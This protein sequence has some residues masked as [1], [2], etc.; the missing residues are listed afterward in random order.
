MHLKRLTGEL[1]WVVDTGPLDRGPDIAPFVGIRHDA[2]EALTAELLGVPLDRT[3][4]SVGDNVG[5]FMQ[6]EYRKWAG[7]QSVDDVLSAIDSA[8][9]RLL[10][11]LSL[12]NLLGVWNITSRTADPGWRYREIAQMLL[13]R[14]FADV[15]ERLEMARAQ[16]CKYEDEIC[17]QFRD[18]ERR[19]QQYMSTAAQSE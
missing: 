2:L 1:S 18:F 11:Y 10:P 8:Q 15:Q 4:A 5:Y 3:I 16:F 7:G 6:G 17:E 9:Q 19:V 13:L 14:R 12:E